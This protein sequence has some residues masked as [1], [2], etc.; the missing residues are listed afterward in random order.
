[1][2]EAVWVLEVENFGPLVVGVD[3]KGRDLYEEVLG[4]ALK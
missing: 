4:L 2:P 3:A 1:M